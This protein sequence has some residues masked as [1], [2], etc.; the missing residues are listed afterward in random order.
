[1]Y[2]LSKVLA[3][4]LKAVGGKIGVN[5][6]SIVGLVS[7]LASSATAFGMMDK[8]D[9]KGVVMNSAFAVSGAFVFAGHLA[10]TLAFAQQ[11]VVSVIT[12]KLVAA[13]FA[14]VLANALYKKIK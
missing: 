5:E 2:I 3:K 11:Y 14:V 13:V 12:G 10:F 7:N 9:K 1:M 6:I 8:M 4:P